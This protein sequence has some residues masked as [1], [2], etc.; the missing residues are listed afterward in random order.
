[1]NDDLIQQVIDALIADGHVM[2]DQHWMQML[3][4]LIH[5]NVEIVNAISRMAELEGSTMCELHLGK[6]AK[7]LTEIAFTIEQVAMDQE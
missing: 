2:V 4:S 1:M 6:L 3:T 5:D 7:R